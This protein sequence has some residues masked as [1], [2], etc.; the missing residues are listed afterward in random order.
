[1][2][3]STLDL[4]ECPAC[5]GTLLLQPAE[6]DLEQV[7]DGSLRC[8]NCAAIYPIKDGIPRFVPAENY[9]HNFGVQWNMFRRTQL[10]SHSGQPISRDRFL[11]Y[12]GWSRADLEGKLVLDAGCGAGR[13]A[14]IAVSLGARVVAVDYSTA[15]EAARDNLKESGDIDFIQ[16]DITALPFAPGT[17]DFVYCLGVIQHTPSPERTFEKLAEA[18]KPGGQLALDSYPKSW[19]NL[20]LAYYWIRPITRR[21]TTER[22]LQ[23]VRR[24]FPPLYSLSRVVCRIPLVGYHLRYLIPVSNYTNVLPLGREQLREW[25]LLDTFDQW[26]PAYDQPQ[27]LGTIRSWFEKAGFRAI[28]VFHSGIFVGRG[29]KPRQDD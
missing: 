29:I 13:F 8:A 18:V 2:R 22:S 16:G 7:V 23:L 24:L 11:S 10:D 27:T 19:K 20:F 9:A 15:I 5:R 6:A 4:L 3:S 26:A 25:A 14:E 21:L 1:M 17:F 28:E 12:T